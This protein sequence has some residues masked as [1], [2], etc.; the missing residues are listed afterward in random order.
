M[1][2]FSFVSKRE[3]VGCGVAGFGLRFCNDREGSGL[4]GFGF[5]V[6]VLAGAP[7]YSRAQAAQL[8]V[9][10]HEKRYMVPS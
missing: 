2:G 6:G 9:D 1:Q 5:R 8:S 4:G 3:G 10:L 7:I